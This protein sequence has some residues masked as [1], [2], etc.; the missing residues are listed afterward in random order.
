MSNARQQYKCIQLYILYKTLSLFQWPFFQ[1][2]LCQPVPECLDLLELKLTEL[3]V[4]NGTVRCATLQ[5]NCH[6]QQTNN[7]LFTSR[8]PFL[9]PN[10]QDQSTEGYGMV[11]YGILEFS[12]PLDTV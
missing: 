6:H 12:I 1:V 7:H 5:S 9:S 4:T 11:W 8:M 10:Q 3:V 2:N